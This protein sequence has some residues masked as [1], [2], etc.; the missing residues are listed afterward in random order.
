MWKGSPLSAHNSL[1]LLAF[2]NT[3]NQYLTLGSMSFCYFWAEL[4]RS[5][6]VKKIMIW[7]NDK[8]Q[9]YKSSIPAL[10]APKKQP[11]SLDS[12]SRMSR[13]EPDDGPAVWA[14]KSRN[15]RPLCRTSPLSNWTS[16]HACG[17]LTG[18]CTHNLYH[19]QLRLICTRI[20]W[21]FV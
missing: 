15:R 18:G 8:N 2:P 19:N 13:G 10:K 20:I 4:W 16:R 21:I 11:V 1:Q 9:Q 12:S 17:S 5:R 6:L 7:I 14:R 3:V